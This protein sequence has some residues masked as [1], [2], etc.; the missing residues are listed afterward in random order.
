MLPH[1]R[2]NAAGPRDPRL[3]TG[4]V[5]PVADH[6]E[7]SSAI[8]RANGNAQFVQTVAAALVS[9]YTGALGLTFALAS[10]PMPLRGFIAPIFLAI[11]MAMA[12]IYLAYLT[13]KKG[14]QRPILGSN[15]DYNIWR[16]TAYFTNFARVSVNTRR[17]WLRAG[18]MALVVGVAFSPAPWIDFGRGPRADIAAETDRQIAMD[19][20]PAPPAGNAEAE[21]LLYAYQLDEYKAAKG[22]AQRTTPISVTIPWIGISIPLDAALMIGALITWL[23]LTFGV[24]W[25]V[26]RRVRRSGT[27]PD[28][29]LSVLDVESP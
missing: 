7:A 11:A 26:D 24:G 13:D 27:T 15:W 10:H 5:Q 14:P 17:G 6:A 25:W 29:L 9:L 4:D 23:F 8:E 18:V 28:P 12:A 3:R 1:P 19:E 22:A 2:D 21:A 20:P 16:R